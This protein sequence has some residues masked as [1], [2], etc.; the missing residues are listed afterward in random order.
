MRGY[1]LCTKMVH[2]T[3]DKQCA[4][5]TPGI[6]RTQARLP[7]DVRKTIFNGTPGGSRTHDTWYRKPVLYPLSYGRTWV[8]FSMKKAPPG[9]GRQIVNPERSL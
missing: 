6:G 3:G 4:V 9:R 2:P 1:F 7:Q 5:A 8:Y